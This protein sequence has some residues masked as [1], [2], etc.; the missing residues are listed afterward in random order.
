M[1]LE[2]QSELLLELQPEYL[3]LY[4]SNAMR[5]AQYF[6]HQNLRLDSLSGIITYGELLLPEVREDC[7]K[8]WG[9]PVSDMYSCEEVGY[10]ALQCPEFGNY[11]CQSESVLVEVLN[12]DNEPCAPGEIG[13]IALTAL[14]NFAMPLIRYAN[15]D[16]A[17]VGFPCPCGRGY[18]VL[19]RLLGRQRN[20]AIGGDGDRF[21]P[22]L[23]RRVWAHIEAIDELQLVQDSSD[24]IEL[25]MVALR[26]LTPIETQSLTDQLCEAL[27]QSYSFTLKYQ[28]DIIRHAN[29]KYERFICQLAD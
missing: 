22:N 16:Y 23:S 2:K 9:A 3:L 8:T 15:R 29:G 12:E 1:P 10:I 27:G 5:L 24:H 28:T 18:P 20:M 4:P 6:R 11:H 21:W 25:R 17:E 19:H 13:R 14:H 26:E 7:F